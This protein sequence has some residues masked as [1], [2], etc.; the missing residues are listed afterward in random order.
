MCTHKM[1]VQTL[2]LAHRVAHTQDRGREPRRGRGNQ[3]SSFRVT[4]ASNR[5]ASV[6]ILA[7]FFSRDLLDSRN[8]RSAEEGRSD[9]STQRGGGLI[10]EENHSSRPSR[11]NRSDDSA[12]HGGETRL[13][14]R[15][16]TIWDLNIFC[17]ALSCRSASHARIRPIRVQL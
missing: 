13:W 6:T 7:Q 16:H 1:E 8:R 3:S 15:D 17:W 5:K 12:S 4:E 11:R 10:S 9:T 2:T 14:M